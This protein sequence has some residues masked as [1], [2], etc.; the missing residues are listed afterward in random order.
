M[1]QLPLTIVGNLTGAPELR[2]T[3]AGIAACRFTIAHNPRQLDKASGEWRDG[4]PTFLDCTV[5][6]QLAEHVAESLEAGHRVIAYG[7]LRTTT[8]ESDG[9]GKTPAGTK[10][11]RLQLDV[12]A[13]G[14]DLT[15]ATA[16]VHKAARSS[17]G[18]VAPDDPWASASKTRPEPASV[19]AGRGGFDDEPP[20]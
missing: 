5:W 12:I 18:E 9:S 4:D 7:H 15:W 1:N 13:I 2:F 20:F 11:S 10:I 3:A 17:R 16:S 19:P 6:R 14:P 8:W